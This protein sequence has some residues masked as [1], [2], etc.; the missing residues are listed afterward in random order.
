[1]NQVCRRSQPALSRGPRG[2]SGQ[3]QRKQKRIFNRV[4]VVARPAS[5]LPEAQRPVEPQSRPVRGA[6]FQINL[7]RPLQLQ[8]FCQSRKKQPPDPAPLPLRCPPQSSPT[9]PAVPPPSP[10]RSRQLRP[11]RPPPPAQLLSARPSHPT[12]ANR[13]LEA[14]AAHP[15]NSAQ[16]PPPGPNPTGSCA[17]SAPPRNSCVPRCCRVAENLRIRAPQIMP[18]QLRQIVKLPRQNPRH[19]QPQRIGSVGAA[20]CT[21]STA[22]HAAFS[23]V[24]AAS[25]QIAIRS[26]AGSIAASS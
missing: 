15:S 23:T 1:M 21:S 26:G 3:P 9:P 25:S 16:S 18:V 8:F 4:S 10:P 2:Q 5:G 7:F 11:P 14:N 22:G 13:P 17:E 19:A 24:A 20:V 6:N 12:R